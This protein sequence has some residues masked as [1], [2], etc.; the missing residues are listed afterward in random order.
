MW[1][2]ASS[3]E[4]KD[5]PDVEVGLYS[6]LKGVVHHRQR[7]KT[8][9][10]YARKISRCPADGSTERAILSPQCT[11]FAGM[12]KQYR[13]QYAEAIYFFN[14][15]RLILGT[16]AFQRTVPYLTSVHISINKQTSIPNYVYIIRT[17]DIP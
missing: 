9:C 17:I 12:C 4:R 10:W 5:L 14:M 16:C 2:S 8:K 13:K 15:N 6:H 1:Q 11:F 7:Y 3:S